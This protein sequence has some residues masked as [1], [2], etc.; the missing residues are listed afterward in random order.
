MTISIPIMILGG[1]AFIAFIINDFLEAREE[2]RRKSRKK[3]RS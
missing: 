3:R 2:K 1:I